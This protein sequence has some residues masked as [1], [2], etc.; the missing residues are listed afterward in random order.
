MTKSLTNEECWEKFQFKLSL[1]I[2]HPIYKE[3]MFF[4]GL[5]AN[6]V[7]LLEQEIKNLKDAYERLNQKYDWMT[8][9]EMYRLRDE[10]KKEKFER[11]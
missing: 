2:P 11:K 8:T 4:D 10:I 9:Q 5:E 7:S 6:Y 1:Q 3:D